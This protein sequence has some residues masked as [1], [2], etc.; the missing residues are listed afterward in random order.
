MPQTAPPRGERR[1]REGRGSA[2]HPGHDEAA[3]NH[4]MAERRRRIKQKENFA[5]LRKLV[6]IISKVNFLTHP[7]FLDFSSIGETSTRRTSTLT[8][9]IFLL[10]S[11]CQADKASIL[12]DAIAYIKDL[13]ER[14]SELE[15]SRAQTESRYENLRMAHEELEQRNKELEAIF[16]AGASFHMQQ[17]RSPRLQS[18]RSSF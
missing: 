17:H 11:P 5:A 18:W 3:T 6:P 2:A 14:I 10:I 7:K 9:G 13:Q 15:A 8:I 4:M 1:P 16:A 12:S